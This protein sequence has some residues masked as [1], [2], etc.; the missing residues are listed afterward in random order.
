[1][2]GLCGIVC[3][4][5]RTADPDELAPI[6]A[7][8]ETRGPEGSRIA[9][10]GPAVLGCAMLATTP[11]ALI[12][13]LPFEHRETGCLLTGDVRLDNRDQLVTAL[14]L[15]DTRCTI[16][17]GELILLTYLKWGIDCPKHLLGDFAFALWDPRHRRL[18][19]ARDHA[20]MRPLVYHHAPG[21]HF[22]LASDPRALL[23]H[24]EIRCEINEERVADFLENRES[25]D[26]T[27]TF[28]R[29]IFRLPPAHALM[30]EDD[31]LRIWQYWQLEPPSR[32]HL[33]SDAAYADA[34]REVFTEAV[35]ARLRSAG[36]VGSMLSGGM[37][38]GAVVAVAS[39]LL[40]SHGLPP[41]STFSAVSNDPS[42][43][44][45][46]AIRAAQTM[47]HID[48]VSIGPDD[49][50]D[51]A[52]DL[53]RMIRKMGE[54]FDV[55]PWNAAAYLAARRKGIKVVLDGAGGDSLFD[56]D[57]MVAWNL[58]RGRLAQAWR[59]ARGER[60]FYGPTVS[61][62][63]TMLIGARHVIVPQGLRDLKRR[64]GAEAR[65]RAADRAS[66]LAPELMHR[67]AVHD[68][69]EAFKRKISVRLDGRCDDRRALVLHRYIL[70]A[71]E[72]YDR[73]AAQAGV[74]ARDPFLD[75]RLIEF[76]LTLPPEQMLKD[77][78]P[79]IVMRRAMA[80]LLPDAVRWRVGKEHVGWQ[81]TEALE[82]TGMIEP[83]AH[84]FA[85]AAKFLAVDRVNGASQRKESDLAVA[86]LHPLR[87][88][89]LLVEHLEFCVS[90]GEYDDQ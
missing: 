75:R 53:A 43:V 32:L 15:A 28:F 87:Y 80:G 34:L 10:S 79:K 54:P 69:R 25:F 46:R 59:E 82:A 51:Y 88:I 55:M 56:A 27:S 7:R 42:C 90:D 9:A 44:E 26:F 64:L 62:T 73:I 3:L 16:G 48:P 18:L 50:P 39:R 35:S 19:C 8:L 23:T 60:M 63:E 5:G 74:E 65:Q 52:E 57:N 71:R 31:R 1:M 17:D 40:Q 58:R 81:F 61:A 68:R 66:L 37:D 47:A 49:F 85:R 86:A 89:R 21:R 12:E 41:L 14:G 36:P 29:G 2:S 78:W 83:T 6:L 67:I 70:A 76:V 24:G 30:I 77:G 38:S 33:P 84:G 45:T 72:R 20:S 11:E 22:A 13:Q 4:D